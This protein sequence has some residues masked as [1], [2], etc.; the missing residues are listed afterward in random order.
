MCV[1][2]LVSCVCVCVCIACCCQGGMFVESIEG[3]YFNVMGLPMHHLS[4]VLAQ[5]DAN[6]Q[7]V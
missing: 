4:K 7:I 2:W 3:C 1:V 6:R 5:L